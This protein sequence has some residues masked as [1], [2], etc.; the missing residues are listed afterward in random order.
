MSDDFNIET[1]VPPGVLVAAGGW[2][3]PSGAVWDIF[4][5]IIWDWDCVDIERVAD[6]FAFGVVPELVETDPCFW[7]PKFTMP[8]G[9]PI[10]FDSVQSEMRPECERL[11][12]AEENKRG[13]RT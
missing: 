10:R 6:A 1:A 7:L 8:R 2:C 9:N 5:E 11:K 4:T 12:R 13:G 3:A